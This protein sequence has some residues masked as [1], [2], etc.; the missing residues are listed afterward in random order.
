VLGGVR[1]F[2]DWFDE[3]NRKGAAEFYKSKLDEYDKKY[4]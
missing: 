1:N 2:E 4:L 3:S